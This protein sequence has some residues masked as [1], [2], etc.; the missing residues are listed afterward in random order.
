[1]KKTV[2]FSLLALL[3][4]ATAC[5]NGEKSSQSAENTPN[6]GNPPAQ[7]SGSKQP[8]PEPKKEPVE[9]IFYSQVADYDETFMD[10]FGNMIQKKYPHITVKHLKAGSN[11]LADVVATGQQ[12]DVLFMSIGQADTLTTYNY[13]YDISEFIKLKNYDLSKLE[14]STVELQKSF[15]NNGMYGL[16][17]FTNTLGFFYNKDLFDKFGVAYP[18]DGMTWD[19]V[20]ELARRLSRTEGETVYKGLVMSSSANI[21]LNQYSVAYLDPVTKKSIFTTDQFKKAFELLTSVAKVPGNELTAQTWS[22]AAQQNMFF[23]DQKAA[24]LLHFVILSLSQLKDQFNWDI[25]T[26]PKLPEKPDVGPQSYPT[27][28]YVTQTSKHKEDA[29]DAIAYL[30]TEEF[31]NHLAR[32]GMLPIL[33]DRVAG[34]AEFGKEVPILQG[35]NVKALIPEKYAPS[36]LNK[37]EIVRGQSPGHTAFFDAYQNYVLGTKDLNTALREAGESLDQK[38]MDLFK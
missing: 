24:M 20:K 38:L 26:Y 35:K 3:L 13:Q 31:Q 12:I 17:V 33:K 14:P 28:F 37:V 2:S 4:A 25:A 1:M 11:K 19:E 21:V 32:R 18:K 7:E 6:T 34:L 5:S 30:T 23:K 8:E 27:Y 29:F 10:V 16:P 9:L 22:L 36:A 15:A